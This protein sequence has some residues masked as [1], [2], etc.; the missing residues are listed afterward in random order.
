MYCTIFENL[1]QSVTLANSKYVYSQKV[2]IELK[3][4]VQGCHSGVAEKC[5][6]NVR[7]IKLNLRSLVWFYHNYHLY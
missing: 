1:I 7:Q 6:S 4:L 3:R 5:I 2:L